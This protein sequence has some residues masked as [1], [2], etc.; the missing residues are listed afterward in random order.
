L[1]QRTTEWRTAMPV[2]FLWAGIPVLLVGGG[3]VIYR[4]IGA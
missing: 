2:I 3:Y 1:S 4:I